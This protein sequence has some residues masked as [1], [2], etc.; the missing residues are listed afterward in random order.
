MAKI[1]ALGSGQT[2]F[3]FLTENGLN[4]LGLDCHIIQ[5]EAIN[6]HTIT[7][8]QDWKNIVTQYRLVAFQE[9]GKEKN[10]FVHESILKQR[11]EWHSILQKNCTPP[12]AI[13]EGDKFIL[14]CPNVRLHFIN[15]SSYDK[16]RIRIEEII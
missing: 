2:R 13:K 16:L 14:Y 3:F 11:P 4:R 12:L 15:Q 7:Q 9:N 5:L 10:L 1:H 8:P 6:N